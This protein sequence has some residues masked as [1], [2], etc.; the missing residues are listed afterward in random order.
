MKKLAFFILFVL[1]ATLL[2]NGMHGLA[3]VA[4]WMFKVSCVLFAFV[5]IAALIHILDGGYKPNEPDD[6]HP[7]NKPTRRLSKY[8][9]ERFAVMCNADLEHREEMAQY[10][11][12]PQEQNNNTKPLKK[13]LND[14]AKLTN[15]SDS[16]NS[17]LLPINDL[18]CIQDEINK[19]LHEL[20]SL[21]MQ[22]FKEEFSIEPQL[23]S[24]R[25]IDNNTWEYIFKLES[26]EQMECLAE[27]ESFL[28]ENIG[29]FHEILTLPD[30]IVSLSIKVCIRVHSAS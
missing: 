27:K 13:I 7:K 4:L 28:N 2:I 11:Q 1:L 16:K 21:Y 20:G 19:R 23:L 18:D 3:T 9:L 15:S 8:E 10:N 22:L 24:A 17:E 5:L 14:I 25:N 6:S 26:K 29:R 12:P 30:N